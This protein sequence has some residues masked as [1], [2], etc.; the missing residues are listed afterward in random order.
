MKGVLRSYLPTLYLTV[1][2]N[3]SVTTTAVVKLDNLLYLLDY[4]NSKT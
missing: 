4:N 1:L 3:I 2:F